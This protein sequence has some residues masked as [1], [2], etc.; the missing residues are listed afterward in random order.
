MSY[1]TYTSLLPKEGEVGSSTEKRPCVIYM[2]GN[3]GNKLE[4]TLR[5]FEILPL[6]ADLLTFDFS[7]C[8]NSGGDQVTL[9]WKEVDDLQ[10]VLD[11]LA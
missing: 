11:Y 2:H 10:A 3:G 8:G 7:G 5:I 9:G 6:G 4:G 1:I